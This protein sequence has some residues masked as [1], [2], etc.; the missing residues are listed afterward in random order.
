M[1]ESGQGSALKPWR[2][3]PDPDAQLTSAFYT[4]PPHNPA[5]TTP[6]VPGRD[7]AGPSPLRTS[8]RGALLTKAGFQDFSRSAACLAYAIMMAGAS[9]TS[10]QVTS[11]WLGLP[12]VSCH[13]TLRWL[14]RHV[15][16]HHVTMA[17]ALCHVTLSH[18]TSR[19][20]GCH[21]MPRH[22]CHD[23]WGV[24]CHHVTTR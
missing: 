22:P 6:S 21:I 12:V 9:I 13:V 24:T 14:G 15:P 2:H 1:W 8:P 16:L 4:P 10:R 19:Q 5:K 20:L 3:R 7:F 11:G 23:D 18:I 17:G